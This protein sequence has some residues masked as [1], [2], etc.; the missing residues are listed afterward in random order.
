MVACE[1]CEAW[2]HPSCI[3]V[4]TSLV[5]S[6]YSLFYCNGCHSSG[7]Y[8]FEDISKVRKLGRTLRKRSALDYNTSQVLSFDNCNSALLKTGE[9]FLHFLNSRG[10]ERANIEEYNKLDSDALH[11]WNSSGQIKPVLVKDSTDLQI[12]QPSVSIN[13]HLIGELVGDSCAVEVLD[14]ATQSEVYPQWTLGQWLTYFQTRKDKR[15]AILNVLSLEVSHT[16]LSSYIRAP[17]LVRDIDWIQNSWPKTRKQSCLHELN[18]YFS[19]NLS[20][21]EKQNR[22]IPLITYPKVQLYCLMSVAGA[23]TDF[24]IDF[25]GSSVWYHVIFGKKIFYLIRPTK[26]NLEAFE[27]WTTSPFQSSI[28]FGDE[29]DEC[30]W[31]IVAAGN[32][33]FI[34]SGWIHAV[35]TP[36]DSLVFG[37]NYL[38]D[39]AVTK[40]L[41]IANL[42]R[43]TGVPDKYLFPFFYKSCW[44][45][46]ARMVV[47]YSYLHD[48]IYCLDDILSPTYLSE[49]SLKI[50][51]RDVDLQSE[52]WKYEANKLLKYLRNHSKH[53]TNE[54]WKKRNR[55]RFSSFLPPKEILK[56][57]LLLD[58]LES[59]CQ[60]NVH[61]Q[62]VSSQV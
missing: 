26:K 50:S 2:F 39:F 5:L 59:I 3:N 7:Q 51:G 35:Y 17:V 24:H 57:F 20:E 38:H 25:G 47:T 61:L 8:T 12:V 58:V 54:S 52:R 22:K 36:E 40:Q 21:S 43:R 44:Y 37:G 34:P 33:F 46:A 45:A 16:K 13:L 11:S 55:T 6:P 53:I 18:K 48:H 56:P 27:R 42:E 4:S 1:I 9:A 14:V 32:T 41:E 31:I 30:S 10:Y 49:L 19:Q 62:L 28:F 15:K 60:L 29:V 23:Y